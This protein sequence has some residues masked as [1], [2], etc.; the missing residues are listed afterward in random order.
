M[1]M[2][3]CGWMWVWVEEASSIGRPTQRKEWEADRVSAALLGHPRGGSVLIP[4]S[5]NL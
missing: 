3:L 5:T 4:S 2:V 1:S